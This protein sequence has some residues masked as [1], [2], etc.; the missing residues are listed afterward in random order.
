MIYEDDFWSV[1]NSNSQMSRFK[2]NT[3]RAAM[4]EAHR[5]A[6][7]NPNDKFYVLHAVR[8]FQ[9]RSVETIH[10]GIPL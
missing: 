10:I 9:T 7:A 6:T 2:H 8:G 3:E 5:L 1:W 4:D